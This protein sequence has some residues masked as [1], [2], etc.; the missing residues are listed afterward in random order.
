MTKSRKTPALHTVSVK[1]AATKA[2]TSAHTHSLYTPKGE[3]PSATGA[4]MQVE[5]IYDHGKLEFVKP[6]KLKRDCVRLVVTIPDEE[7]D[8]AFDHTVSEEV[9]MLARE[10]RTQFDAIR[11]APCH[12]TMSCRNCPK[13]S[14]TVSKSSL[15]ATRS[16]GC[17]KRGLVDRSQR[18]A[19]VQ[20]RFKPPLSTSKNMKILVTG[21]AGFIGFHTARRLLERGDSVVGFDSV[22]NYYDPSLKEA[23]LKTLE[24]LAGSSCE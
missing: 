3:H 16:R 7:V 19:V 15:Y 23:R 17:V 11:N 20:Q 21:N 10:I 12:S 4:N 18:R 1:R 5:A 2:P 8:D 22:N 14:S 9:L 6:L 24:E 13:N